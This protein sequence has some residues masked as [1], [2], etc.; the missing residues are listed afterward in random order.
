MNRFRRQ[1]SKTFE[2]S[3][4]INKKSLCF[5]FGILLVFVETLSLSGFFALKR[6]RRRRCLRLSFFHVSGT[7]DKT[8]KYII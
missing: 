6:L 3:K 4:Q 7:K 5:V 8:P 1:R 2:K